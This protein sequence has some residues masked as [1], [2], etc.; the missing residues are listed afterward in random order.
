[1]IFLFLPN[2]TIGVFW[3]VVNVRTDELQK[4]ESGSEE[5]KNIGNFNR[6][7]TLENKLYFSF[8]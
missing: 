1:M 4:L 5:E 7:F 2:N 6:N 3:M 8:F